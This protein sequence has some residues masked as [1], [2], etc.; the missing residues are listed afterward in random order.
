[1]EEST[2]G[3]GLLGPL[4]WGLAGWLVTD[5]DVDGVRLDVVIEPREA[6]LARRRDARLQQALRWQHVDALA[7]LPW[8]APV[9][10]RDVPLELQLTLGDFPPG[11]VE[12][13]GEHVRRVWM[14]PFDVVAVSRT[15][16]PGRASAALDA[17]SQFAAAAPRV[18]VVDG[19]PSDD[20]VS[21]AARLGVAVV[22][23]SDGRADVAWGP[24]STSKVCDDQVAW[25]VSEACYRRVMETV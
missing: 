16:G 2:S 23:L 14:A 13:D 18:L 11:V 15:V 20:V 10:L 7:S 21:A 4:D 9:S 5:V 6:E 8:M 24:P 12:I 1:M 3:W 25:E 19:D 22:R 17:I